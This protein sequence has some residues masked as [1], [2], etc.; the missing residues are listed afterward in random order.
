[1]IERDR[2]ELVEELQRTM[3]LG[4]ATHCAV[5]IYTFDG[6]NFSVLMRE[7][8]RQRDLLL[9]VQRKTCS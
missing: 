2:R 3:H 8:W 9:F 7:V 6:A 5:D 4:R 1:M